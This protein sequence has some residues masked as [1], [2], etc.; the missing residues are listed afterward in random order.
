MPMLI[1]PGKSCRGPL[2]AALA[3]AVLWVGGCNRGAAP[4]GPS[5][6]MAV[7][8]TTAEVASRDVP[9]YLDEIGKCAPIQ[10]VSIKPLVTGMIRK[11]HFVDGADVKK[12]DVLFDIDPD[13]YKALLDQSKAQLA[14]AKATFEFAT[15]DFNRIKDV[16]RSV[17]PQSDFDAKQNAI[18]V[19][20]AQMEAAKAA[21]EAAA[22]NLQYCRIE[23]PLDGMAGQ[24]LIDQGNIVIANNPMGPS[25]AMVTIQQL[26]PIYAD[27][28]VTENDLKA[29]RANMAKGTLK[30][31]VRL[32]A[33]Q[34]SREGDLSFLDNMVQDGSGTIKL[35]ATVKNQDRHF[36]PGQFVFVRL[37]LEVRK[38]ALLV[39][40]SAVQVGQQGQFVYVVKADST[41]EM[42]P[43][44]LGQPQGDQVVILK[45][46]H[47]GEKVVATGQ[48]MVFPGA[49]L[50]E[51]M[52]APPEG[53]PAT[54]PAS[55]LPVA[56]QGGER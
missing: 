21:I 24:R 27:F 2:G 6:P 5:G 46:I 31:L 29:V 41:A 39:P 11:I 8:V 16:P 47:A 51:A 23:S 25:A 37:V 40:S 22:L 3:A 53:A 45:G 43:I 50:R 49:P 19:A 32:P 38:D 7:L 20:K 17:E 55:T 10:S 36:W 54:K 18:D 26:D 15:V 4:Q 30:T 44:E 33:D 56:S 34:H 42:R 52:A 35:R 28:T 12:G 48:M 14:Q 13:P 1:C 9:V